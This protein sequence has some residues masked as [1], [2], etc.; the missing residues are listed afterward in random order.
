MMAPVG[1][2]R[3]HPVWQSGT[4]NTYIWAIHIRWNGKPPCVRSVRAHPKIFRYLNN[5]RANPFEVL[6]IWDKKS[7]A[8]I[9]KMR[10]K[11][12]AGKRS[13]VLMKWRA[14]MGKCLREIEGLKTEEKNKIQKTRC[15]LHAPEDSGKGDQSLKKKKKVVEGMI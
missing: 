9:T 12:K 1:N 7:P 2:S 8:S 5:P 3:S 14:L 4:L 13:C 10:A 11:W 6:E 15:G